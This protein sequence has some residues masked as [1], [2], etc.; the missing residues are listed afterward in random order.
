MRT[1]P[2]SRPVEV[3]MYVIQACKQLNQ[4]SNDFHDSEQVA[5]RVNQLRPLWEPS[6]S[7][8]EILDICDTEGNSQNGGGTFTV[9]TSGKTK[10]IRFEPSPDCTSP[11]STRRGSSAIG[12]IGH[13]VPGPNPPGSAAPGAFGGI[14]HSPSTT[15]TSTFHRQFTSPQSGF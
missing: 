15:S 5:Y 4:G 1:A 9:Q 10:F 12:E 3:R 2:V 13:P 14:G 8:E 7:L 11:I 6:I